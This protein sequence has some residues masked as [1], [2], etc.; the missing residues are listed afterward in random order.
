MRLLL[1]D[2]RRV[3]C[4]GF[5]GPLV[6]TDPKHDRDRWKANSRY[7]WVNYRGADPVY[8]FFGD[9]A[10]YPERATAAGWATFRDAWYQFKREEANG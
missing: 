1:V 7:W 10:L 5:C 2:T 4:Q 9:E 8:Q 3:I 6:A